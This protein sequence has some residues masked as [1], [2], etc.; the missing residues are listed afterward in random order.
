M[1]I[2]TEEGQ[3]LMAFE[4]QL[5]DGTSRGADEKGLYKKEGEWRTAWTP[6]YEELLQFMNAIYDGGRNSTMIIEEEDDGTDVN[7]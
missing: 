4:I 5:S 2:K 6:N 1:P 3:D 7:N